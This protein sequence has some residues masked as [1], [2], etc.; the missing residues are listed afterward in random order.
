MFIEFTIGNYR[1][2]N[3][4]QTLSFRATGLVSDH[5]ELDSQNIIITDGGKLLKT[6][7]IYGA[8]ASGKTNLIKGLV[9]FQ[10]LIS[11]SLDAHV[12]ES[13]IQPFKLKQ[14]LDN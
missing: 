12:S 5:K 6:L 13:M 9:F 4:L 1:S 10:K 3:S 11:S 2:F 7:G 14:N 8:N